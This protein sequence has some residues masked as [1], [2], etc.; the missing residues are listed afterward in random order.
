MNAAFKAIE[1]YGLLSF[2]AI[3]FL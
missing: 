2:F 3:Y 1:L